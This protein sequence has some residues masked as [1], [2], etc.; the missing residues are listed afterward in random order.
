[1][2]DT[3]NDMTDVWIRPWMPSNIRRIHDIHIQY[4]VLA[5]RRIHLIEFEIRLLAPPPHYY[6]LI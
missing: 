1:M 2:P 4:N 3:D 6:L 5:R